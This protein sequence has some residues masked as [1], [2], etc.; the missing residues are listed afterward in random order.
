MP[1]PLEILSLSRVRSPSG[2][3]TSPVQTTTARGVRDGAALAEITGLL[4]LSGWPGGMRVIVRRER[5]HPGAQLHAFEERDGYR[6][7]P[8]W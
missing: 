5:P 6:S 2:R 7:P 4:N 3:G 8:N 1:S